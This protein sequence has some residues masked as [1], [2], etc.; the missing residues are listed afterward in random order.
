[1]IIVTKHHHCLQRS[2][3]IGSYLAI[4]F[5]CSIFCIARILIS[6]KC[7]TSWFVCLTIL[8]QQ[9]YKNKLRVTYVCL[10]IPNAQVLPNQAFLY[11]SGY[12]SF[13]AHTPTHQL[14]FIHAIWIRIYLLISCRICWNMLQGPSRSFQCWGHRWRACL[15]G[16]PPPCFSLL[17]LEGG[18]TFCSLLKTSRVHL[19][20]LIADAN[21]K[22]SVHSDAPPTLI[23]SADWIY[24]RY[25]QC[26]L[27]SKS[28]VKHANVSQPAEVSIRTCIT[29]YN[30]SSQ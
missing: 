17:Q 5:S 26:H 9:N 13:A 25:M 4:H 6:N 30:E 7:K 22:F 23:G 2:I 16:L 27:Y 24:K 20:W 3:C 10:F 12:C 18:G 8:H 29:N 11:C 21:A 15:V 14:S 1:M 28:L 19:K